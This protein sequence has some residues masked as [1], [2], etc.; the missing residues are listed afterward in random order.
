MLR[1][2]PTQALAN[3]AA[4]A[5]R[6][7]ATPKA[8]CQVTHVGGRLGLV[9]TLGDQFV[10]VLPLGALNDDCDEDEQAA[11]ARHAPAI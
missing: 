3:N 11:L 8:A 10:C 4:T 7:A 2:A 6:A 5:G 1:Q 9:L